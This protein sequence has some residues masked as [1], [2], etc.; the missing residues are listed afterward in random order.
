MRD[1]GGWNCDNGTVKY[2]LLYRSGNINSQDEDLFIKQLGIN[3]EC[4]LTTDEIP[5][6]PNKM[7]YICHTSYAMYSLADTGAW[8]TNLSGIFE[9]VKYGDPVVFH[10][11]MGADRTGTL[12]CI[13]L[14]LLGVSQSDIDKDY[15]LTSFYSVRARNGNYQ[16]GTSDW[17]HLMASIQ[18]LDGSTFRDKCVTFVL[19][20]GFS[21]S[22]VNAYRNAMIDGTPEPIIEQNY[23]VTNNL[24]NCTTSNSNTQVTANDSYS[25]VIT[26]NT[27]YELDGATVSITMGGVNITPTVYS[28]GTISIPSVTGDIIISISAVAESNLKELFDNN[29]ATINV[30]FDSSGDTTELNGNFV[31]DFIPVS[32][33]TT[34]EPWRIHIK[35]TE[36][37]TRFRSSANHESILFCK[38]DQSLVNTNYG[39]LTINTSTTGTN[40]LCKHNDSGGGIYIDIN[41][42]GD[43]NYIPSTFFDLSQVAYIR[44]CMTYSSGTAITST[45][46]LSTVSITAD[47]IINNI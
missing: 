44:V 26:A 36:D 24:T 45:D 1:L 18:A 31:T 8:R 14:G 7:R 12:A 23:T 19:S 10:C 33:L 41:M 43:G 46:T 29:A 21:A 25:A 35:D 4:D 13:L 28:N 11:S 47:N 38:A 30:R 6:F 20:L 22:D 42:T 2:G 37:S 15:E 40:T 17:A 9:A 5:A 27:G 32:G 16:G 39:R 34:S 3:T